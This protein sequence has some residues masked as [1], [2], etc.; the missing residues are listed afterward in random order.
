LETWAIVYNPRAG[1]FRPGALEA[2]RRALR[3]RGVAT[4]LL[5]TSGPGHATALAREARDVTR[6]AVYGGDG[7]LNEA[8][9]GLLGRELPLLFIPG[10]TANVMAHELGLPHDPVQAALTG[11][12]A[13]P[14]AV[15]PGLVAGRA[16]LLMAGFGFDGEAVRT[17]SPGLKRWIGKGAYVLSGLHAAMQAGPP[18]RVALDGDGT[19]EGRWLVLARAGHYGGG[20]RVHPGAGLLRPTLGLVMVRR[21]WLLPFLVAHLGLNRHRER[22]GVALRELRHGTL[23]CERPVPVQVDGEYFTSGSRFELGLAPQTVPLCIP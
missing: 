15:R 7:T 9:N 12:A 17:V 23:W 16:F 18:L 11:L 1:R 22:A 6:L 21:R 5:P 13:R 8:A 4:Q 10:G 3:E 20:F 2:I 19:V 14:Q